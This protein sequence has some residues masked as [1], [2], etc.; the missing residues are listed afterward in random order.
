MIELVENELRMDMET[1]DVLTD[2][3]I[4]TLRS[5]A[6]AARERKEHKNAKE[7]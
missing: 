3:E 7:D 4:I 5:I 2:E 1:M 6:K